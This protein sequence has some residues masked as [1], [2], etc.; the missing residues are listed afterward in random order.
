MNEHSVAIAGG[1]P[2]G[3]M[4][5]AELALAEVDVAV[6]ERRPD[7]R[8]RSAHGSLT[9]GGFRISGLEGDSL[10][11]V[12]AVFGWIYARVRDTHASRPARSDRLRALLGRA[13][14]GLRLCC[15]TDRYPSSDPVIRYRVARDLRRTVQIEVQRRS[16]GAVAWIVFFR[17]LLA[18]RH[19]VWSRCDG[20]SRATRRIVDWFATLFPAPRPLR[21]HRYLVG[22]VRRTQRQVA[23]TSSWP[24]TSSRASSAPTGTQPDRPEVAATPTPEPLEGPAS[25]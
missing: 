20:S 23:P 7:H 14:L 15:D 5:A 24:A 12:A 1:G 13:C 19:L 17:Q 10:L 16:C 22:Y 9:S 8:A 11:A 21:L 25:D 6:V 2:A 3:M 4:L 18:F